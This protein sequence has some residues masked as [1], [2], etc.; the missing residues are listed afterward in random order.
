M[1]RFLGL[2]RLSESEAKRMVEQGLEVRKDFLELLVRDAGG[3]VDGFWLTN[4][5]DWDVVCIVTIAEGSSADGA[6]ATVARRAAGLTSRERWIELADASDV[7]V[8]LQQMQT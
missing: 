2:L 6:A 7:A 3:T 5:G 1:G 4:V 8:A